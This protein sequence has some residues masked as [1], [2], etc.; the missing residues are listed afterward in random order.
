MLR[1]AELGQICGWEDW[2]SQLTCPLSL[3]SLPCLAFPGRPKWLFVSIF[4]HIFSKRNTVDFQK[5]TPL[6]QRD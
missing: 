2:T 5:S 6:L 3:P 1:E 4:G